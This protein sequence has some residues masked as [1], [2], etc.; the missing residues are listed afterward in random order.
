V[1]TFVK[2]GLDKQGTRLLQQ[3]SFYASD[4]NCGCV[5]ADKAGHRRQWVP[6]ADDFE[7]RGYQEP[8]FVDKDGNLE[9]TS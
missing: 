7:I 3:F 6:D 5:F 4:K 1:P 8:K 9:P 2:L